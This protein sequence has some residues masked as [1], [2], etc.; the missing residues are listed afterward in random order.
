MNKWDKRFLELAK[1][2]STYSKDPSSQVGGVIVDDRNRIVSVGYNGFPRG[3]ED[4]EERYNDRDTKLKM[5][6]HAEV[7]AILMAH[8]DLSSHT[9]YTYPFMPCSNCAGMI[10]QSGISRCVSIP[11]TGERYE[12]WKDAFKL[13]EIMFEE[14]GV[15]MELLDL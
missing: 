4:T 3:V 13:T 8:K 7:N 2:V 1:Q 10:I 9:I 5:I 12:R 6:V 14:A 11:V 15:K